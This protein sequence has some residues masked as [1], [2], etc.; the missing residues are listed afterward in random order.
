MKSPRIAAD[1]PPDDDHEFLHDQREAD[2]HEDVE[3]V[4]LL[5]DPPEQHGLGQ[6]REQPDGERRERHGGPEARAALDHLVG[7]I[8]AEQVERPVREVHELQQPED[9]AQADRQ[10]E[11]EHPQADAVQDL[12]QVGHAG[13]RRNGNTRCGMRARPDVRSSCSRRLPA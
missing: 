4:R 5:V 2:G 6:A 12:E 9:D 1:R 11:V 7:Q 10:Q 8:G 13:L 3:S